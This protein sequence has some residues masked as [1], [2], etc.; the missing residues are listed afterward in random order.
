MAEIII[1]LTVDLKAPKRIFSGSVNGEIVG[2]FFTPDWENIS[3]MHRQSF[4]QR[5]LDERFP[6]AICFQNI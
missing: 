5:G 1:C 6:H 2:I 3:S 4:Q